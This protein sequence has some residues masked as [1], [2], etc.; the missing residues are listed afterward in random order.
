M[1][2]STSVINV[3]FAIFFLAPIYCKAQTDTTAQ[4]LTLSQAIDSALT[5]NL[6]VK[7]AQFD[8]GINDANLTLAKAALLPSITGTVAA[9]KVFGRV[10]DPTTNTFT[11]ASVKLA[12]GNLYADVTLFQGFQRINQIKANKY[13]LEAGK[14]NTRKVKNDLVL[15]IL[16]TYLQLLSNQELLKVAKQQLIVSREELRQQEKFF[17][18]K[19][20]T[21]ADL[22]M[23]KSVYAGSDLNVINAQN[24]VERTYLLLSQLMERNPAH[25][26]VAVSPSDDELN[27]LNTR[28]TPAD[29]Y[30]RS[31]QNFPDVLLSLNRRLAT[32]KA[33]SVARGK[34]LPTLSMGGTINTSYSSNLRTSVTTQITGLAPIG[35]VSTSGDQVVTPVYQSSVL[36]F[37]EQLKQN[38][39]QAV[40]FT[41]VI[42]VLNGLQS[43]VN[44]RKAKIL[45]QEA[46]LDEQIVK[47]NLNKVINEAVLDLEAAN[48]K[49]KAAQANFTS[50]KEAFSAMSDRYTVGLA[51]G[52]DVLVAVT[53]R[54]VAEFNVIQ[55]KYDLVFKSKLIDYYL[56]NPL[57][58]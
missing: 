57:S 55:A 15:S 6:N 14:N 54:N 2:I 43:R 3:L 19:Q 21:V 33:V 49:Y 53:G 23:A 38:F 28:Y 18:V 35:V 47:T 12:Q 45:N 32:E 20:K 37:G 8:E 27:I 24:E 17:K 25:R 29:I 52:V 40:G 46:R 5:N 9:Y 11:D 26:F 22:A 31:L 50:A 51:D 10:L 30:T 36:S 41:L 16:T 1:K 4:V 48:K 34:L 44:L 58:L 56:G 7:K 42:P 39:N 13:L